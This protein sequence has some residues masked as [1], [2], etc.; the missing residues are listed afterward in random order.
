MAALAPFDVALHVDGHGVVVAQSPAPGTPM[1]A[2]MPCRLV[3]AGPA[4]QPAA[5]Q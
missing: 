4:A 2:G 3:L 5:S 1:S